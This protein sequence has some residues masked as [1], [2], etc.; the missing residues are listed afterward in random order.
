MQQKHRPSGKHE[1]QPDAAPDETQAKD[2]ASPK[3]PLGRRAYDKEL[4]RLHVEL[5][6]LQEWVHAQGPQGLHRVRRAATAPARAA[7][8]R[9]S[10]SA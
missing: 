1:H 2:E 4:E 7:P 10:P 5:V 6:K 3:E 9:R 8:S